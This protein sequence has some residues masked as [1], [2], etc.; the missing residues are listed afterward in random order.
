MNKFLYT[1][2]TVSPKADE[3]AELRFAIRQEHPY[4]RINGHAG[5][6]RWENTDRMFDGPSGKA[7]PLPKNYEV[8]LVK[9][10]LNELPPNWTRQHLAGY[11]GNPGSF[12]LRGKDIGDLQLS[13]QFNDALT[14][15]WTRIR[16]RDYTDPT[17]GEGKWIR[18]VIVPKLHKFVLR[19]HEELHGLAVESVRLRVEAEIKGA[20]HSLDQLHNEIGKA[21]L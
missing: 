3:K 21:V 19:H 10:G 18:D 7:Q 9:A 17:T 1:T 13:L 16:V 15:V 14:V 4:P 20:K 6:L 2:I 5:T 11:K 8:V 12:K